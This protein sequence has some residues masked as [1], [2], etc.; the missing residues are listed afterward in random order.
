MST[1]EK[2]SAPSLTLFR[3][4]IG[5]LLSERAKPFFM[6]NLTYEKCIPT[7]MHIQTFWKITGASFKLHDS[8]YIISWPFHD[9]SFTLNEKTAL[10][11]SENKIKICRYVLNKFGQLSIF[12]K[13]K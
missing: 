6:R 10:K 9:F 12:S 7:M 1:Y 11:S 2:R 13:C 4:I 8:E 5:T 3:H